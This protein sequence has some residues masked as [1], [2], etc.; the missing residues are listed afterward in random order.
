MHASVVHTAARPAMP[1]KATLLFVDDE[2]R[3]L[4]SLRMMFAQRYRIR[5]TTSG[6]EALDILRQEQVH[7]LISDQRMPIMAG[8]ELLRQARE[9]SPNT[10]RLLLTGYSDLEAITGSINDGEVFRYISKPWN[11]ED[12][13]VTID[14][15]VA[16]ARQLETAPAVPAT[17]N[18]V[19]TSADRILIIDED[20][21]TAKEIKAL[22][23]EQLPGRHVLEWAT[24]VEAVLRILGRHEVSLVISEVRLGGEDIT[25]LVKS[26]KRHQPHIVTLALTSYQDSSTLV[27]LINQAQIHRFLLKPVRRNMTW[28]GIESGLQRHHA[29]KSTPQLAH[30]HRVEQSTAHAGNGQATK[31]ILDFFRGL[32][33]TSS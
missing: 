7:A 12:I 4:R 27:G 9:I 28:R 8:I 30:R 10:M 18:Q 11:P 24:D 22:L 29:M 26:L 19:G 15:A 25:E 5:T 3:I 33:R 13:R 23:E 20:P 17:K 31:R 6:F 32:G 21:G 14:D 1:E 2:E 16:I